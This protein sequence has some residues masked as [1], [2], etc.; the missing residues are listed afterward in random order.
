MNFS[1]VE[2]RESDRLIIGC[3]SE[4]AAYVS[5]HLPKS[6]PKALVG[7]QGLSREQCEELVKISK[8]TALKKFAD[9]TFWKSYF[10]KDPSTQSRTLGNIVKLWSL[11]QAANLKEKLQDSMSKH[12]DQ[13][14]SD[15][16]ANPSLQQSCS[17]TGDSRPK[18][19]Q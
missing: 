10:H 4:K 18:V 15:L 9:N 16:P 1:N 13:L 3:G 8:D 19:G 11:K 5:Q 17:Q 2:M 7:I 12:D 14:S 6:W